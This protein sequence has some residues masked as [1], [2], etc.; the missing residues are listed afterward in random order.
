MSTAP[1]V[2]RDERTYAIE[3]ASYRWAYTFMSFALLIDVA[4]RSFVS[5]EAA[6]DLLAF[7]VI[8]GLICTWY[9]ARHKANPPYRVWIA[10][11]IICATMAILAALVVGIVT[12]LG[13]GPASS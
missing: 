4:V 12:Y 9:Q 3:T 5:K 10:V 11:A 8:G 2:E 13:I 6:W 7:V 1:M